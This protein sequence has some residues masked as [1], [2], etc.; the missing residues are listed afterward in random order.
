MKLDKHGSICEF[1]KSVEKKKIIKNCHGGHSL[2]RTL[3]IG[4]SERGG[5]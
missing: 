1:K 4:A 2:K 5:G 3:P